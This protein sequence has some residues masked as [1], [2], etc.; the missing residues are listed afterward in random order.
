[1]QTKGGCGRPDSQWL[2]SMIEAISE[3][4]HERMT[5]YRSELRQR[6]RRRRVLC[7]SEYRVSCRS[8]VFASADDKVIDSGANKGENITRVL[9]RELDVP[10][11]GQ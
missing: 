9:R 7:A 11:H 3:K 2:V 1:M 5:D 8:S 10:Q 4:R 6:V